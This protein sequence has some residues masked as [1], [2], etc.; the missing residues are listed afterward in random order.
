MAAAPPLDARER[1]AL[2][3]LFE[4][5]GPDAPT[6][7]EGWATADLAAHLVVRERDPRSSPGIM[8]GGRYE[9]YT[10]K[11]MERAKAHGYEWL[12]ER[13]RNGPPFGPF[14][15]PGLRELINL[16]EY[17]IHHEDV[18]RANS[19]GPR[20]EAETAEVEAA[21]WRMAKRGARLQLRRVPAGIGVELVTPSGERV[22]AKRGNADRTVVLHGRPG[23][24]TLYLSG[25]RG[26][27]DVELIGPEDAVAAFAQAK[28]GF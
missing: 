24:I 4:Q 10:N 6:L 13:V 1:A 16:G 26:A 19:M 9:A 18:R 28:L 3:D 21:L 14:L 8:F 17:F 25:R 22:V 23:E 27:A 11:L 7:C 15:V 20:P 2:C 5:L 12:V